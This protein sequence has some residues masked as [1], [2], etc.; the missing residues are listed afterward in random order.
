[1]TVCT[2]PLIFLPQSHRRCEKSGPALFR[3][4]NI[5]RQN[6]R[7]VHRPFDDTA[8]REWWNLEAELFRSMRE[9]YAIAQDG[10]VLAVGGSSRLRAGRLRGDLWFHLQDAVQPDSLCG[11]HCWGLST[12]GGSRMAYIA[13]GVLHELKRRASTSI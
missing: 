1:D 7:N 3:Y 13:E 2:A 6:V 12:H 9:D 4:E 5:L 10:P 11:G 8:I